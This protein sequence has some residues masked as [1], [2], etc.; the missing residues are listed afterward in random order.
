MLQIINKPRFETRG[1]LSSYSLLIYTGH[2]VIRQIATEQKI[3]RESELAKVDFTQKFLSP[4]ATSKP[5]S[6]MAKSMMTHCSLRYNG[7]SNVN[8]SLPRLTSSKSFFHPVLQ[9]S[10]PLSRQNPRW[11][12]VWSLNIF[13]K[14][15]NQ[16]PC[17]YILKHL[18]ANNTRFNARVKTQVCWQVAQ[19]WS[20]Q[21]CSKRQTRE[22]QRRRTNSVA[23][24]LTY[25]LV[26]RLIS[27]F[28]THTHQK[29]V[30]SPWC[31][32]CFSLISYDVGTFCA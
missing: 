28:K 3:I 14:W 12:T 9:A 4:S 26:H 32:E 27:L 18:F 1:L 24:K 7:R 10:Q 22:K 29:Q 15:I 5:I 13:N 31:Q 20:V 16:K 25:Y 8:L 6:F 11:S 21:K 23:E 19:V 17:T 2:W 30:L